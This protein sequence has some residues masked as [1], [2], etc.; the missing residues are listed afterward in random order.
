VLYRL[1]VT[2]QFVCRHSELE[3]YTPRPF[4]K[5]RCVAS[6][7]L[8]AEG[9]SVDGAMAAEGS[10]DKF[11]VLFA[12][13][14]EERPNAAI[15]K[16][17]S[18]GLFN[19]LAPLIA[20]S[21]EQ[22][23]SDFMESKG[24]AA[25][26]C[27]TLADFQMVV[28]Q[29][30]TKVAEDTEDDVEDEDID[31]AVVAKQIAAI[32]ERLNSGTIPVIQPTEQRAVALK[33]AEEIL[34]WALNCDAVQLQSYL[35]KQFDVYHQSNPTEHQTP[36]SL[37]RA[38]WARESYYTHLVSYKQLRLR[39]SVAVQAFLHLL[40]SNLHKDKNVESKV[41]AIFMSVEDVVT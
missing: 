40:P 24:W 28:G 22:M 11:K 19:L 31:G 18:V 3:S 21:S 27:F 15:D 13:V 30:R 35:D 32:V 10:G 2:M 33:D 17:G 20:G 7:T 38:R 25:E 34:A 26:H 14:A 23:I 39:V 6:I 16:P 37:V 41:H 5:V 12:S 9:V 36:T 4:L 29:L 8:C 1:F